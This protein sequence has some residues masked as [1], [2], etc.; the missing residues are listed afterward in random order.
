MRARRKI[1]EIQRYP[2]YKGSGVDSIKDGV[3]AGQREVLHCAPGAQRAEN[4]IKVGYE[5][6]F[7]RR[8][9][10]PELMRSPEEIRDDI[11]ALE[12][13]T[14]GLLGDIVGGVKK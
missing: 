12:E 5:I 9:Y 13:E 8:F 7:T 10:K 3:L 11:L 2:E 1:M 4:S 6:S 14:R